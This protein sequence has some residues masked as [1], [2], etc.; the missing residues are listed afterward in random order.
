MIKL[1]DEFSVVTDDYNVILRRRRVV[2]KGDNA[3]NEYWTNEG[4]YSDWHQALN[5]FVRRQISGL[6]DVRKI[7]ERLDDVQDVIKSLPV[8]AMEEIGR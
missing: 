5:D 3:G 7:L 2:E 8:L 1:N 4:F 6:D